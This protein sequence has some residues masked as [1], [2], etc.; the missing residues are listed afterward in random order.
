MQR[1]W[2]SLSCLLFGQ[3]CWVCDEW[4]N[5]LGVALSESAKICGVMNGIPTSPILFLKESSMKLYRPFAAYLLSSR[6]ALLLAG[7]VATSSFACADDDQRP[8]GRR[9]GKEVRVEGDLGPRA[10]GPPSGRG[11]GGQGRPGF[12]PGPQGPGSQGRG[13]QG[14]GPGGFGPGPSGPGPGG[15][16][17]AGPA[18][19]RP[20]AG[21][22]G[23]MA[24]R[25]GM[26]PEMMLRMIPVIGVLDADKDG[27]I[28]AKEISE[29][30]AALK[31]LDRNG[32]GNL[33]TDELRPSMAQ[34]G[35]MAARRPGGV[36]GQAPN[37]PGPEGRGP[38]GPVAGGDRSVVGRGE[39]MS[40]MFEQR[41]ANKDG[42]LR[43][44]EIP[45]QMAARLDRIDQ[46][47]DGAI[48]RD[49]LREMMGRMQ[50][51]GP[52]GARPGRGPAGA[53]GRPDGRGP[54]PGGEVPRRPE[55]RD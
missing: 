25:S 33:T 24:W 51:A 8:D 47:G 43:G 27:S 4:H 11:P 52:D 3:Q 39:M 30:S 32:D 36:E 10:G 9:G 37:Q 19:G 31:K 40:R 28:S 20:D 26:N 7:V 41:D 18:A 38:K 6:H 34:R 13:P 2:F 45:E 35:E 46:N 44:D 53:G 17:G 29:A 16:R 15:P 54:R 12:G 42:Q 55:S 48:S 23:P 21:G 50:Q 49:E 1:S 5:L 22:F 14:F